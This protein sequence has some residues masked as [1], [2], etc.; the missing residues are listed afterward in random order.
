[1]QNKKNDIEKDKENTE[2]KMDENKDEQDNVLDEIDSIDEKLTKTRK[3]IDSKEDEISTTDKKITELGE[4]IDKLKEEIKTLKERIAKRDKLLKNRLRAI[5]KSG[6]SMKYI[7]V[8]LGSKSFTDFINRSSAVNTIMDQ[9]KT[10][11]EEHEA[12]KLDL[13]TKQVAVE[14]KKTEVE[15][16]KV[17]LE[18]Q[19]DELVALKE[20]LDDQLDEKETL[21]AQLEDEYKELEEYNLTI[22][23]EQE[24]VSAQEGSIQKA[25]AMAESEKKELEQLAKEEAERDAAEKAKREAAARAEKKSSQSKQ[26]SQSSSNNSSSGGSTPPASTPAPSGDFIRPVGN[27]ITS[28]FGHRWGRLHAGID[29]GTP[30]GTTVKASASGS[31]RTTETTRGYGTTIMVD[32]YV[33]GQV[34]TTLYAH[35]SSISVSPGQTVKQG[36][37]IGNTG[38]TGRSTGPHLHFEVHPGGWRNPSNPMNFIN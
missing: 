24:I 9:D 28:G 23:E 26:T 37:V 31:V 34:D 14:D 7:E 22:E 5:Q 29:F 21:M 20:D 35:V 11:M 3:N 25:K 10:I 6:G 1:M 15:N 33:N 38:N 2:G 27:G 18:E 8:I 13:E 30:I 4:E 19:K 12:D 36:Q 16:K 32:H 17:A